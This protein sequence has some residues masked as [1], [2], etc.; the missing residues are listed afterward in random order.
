MPG[1]A[2]RVLPDIPDNGAGCVDF[3][4]DASAL[5]EFRSLFDHADELVAGHALEGIQGV[6]QC[7]IGT[8]HA[9][10][11]HAHAHFS[12]SSRGQRQVFS[13]SQTPAGEPQGFHRRRPRA[14][15][16]RVLPEFKLLS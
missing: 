16:R 6:H 10:P 12:W 7:Q 5:E 13:K 9:R 11:E 1:N 15:S 4:D 8:A 2:S 3:A 14:G